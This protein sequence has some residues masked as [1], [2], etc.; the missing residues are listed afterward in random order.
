MDL[1]TQEISTGN[2][3]DVL[4]DPKTKDQLQPREEQSSTS[5]LG[6]GLV[7]V[8]PRKGQGGG[9]PPTNG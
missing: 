1:R 8:G 3:F 4:N 7:G 5:H 9:H 2:T 6:G